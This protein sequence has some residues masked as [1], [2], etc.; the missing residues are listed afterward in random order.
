MMG[1]CAW[2]TALLLLL[3]AGAAVPPAAGQGVDC[4]AYDSQ[5]WA[6]SVYY[7][8]P[9]QYAALDPDGNGI[10]CEELPP[11]IAPASW[12]NA[13][14]TDA[15]LAQFVSVTDGDTIHVLVNGQDEPVR[16][17]LIDTPETHDPNDPAECFGQEATAFAQWLY[18]LGGQLYLETDVSNRDRYDR[19]LRYV[20]LDFGDGEVYLAN[21]V[22]VRS[23]FA[24]LYT[25]P[26]M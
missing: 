17:I 6:Q 18:S 13:I 7:A 3:A 4:S 8:N 9:T 26:R 2:A 10:A 20:W 15:V 14:P 21:E 16:L 22:M 23:G 1:R 19:L 25:Y 5:I 12:T 24:A 11:G